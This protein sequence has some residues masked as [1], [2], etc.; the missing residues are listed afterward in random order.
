V[1]VNLDSPGD[2]NAVG[3]T[4]TYDSSLTF[5][6]ATPGSG[7]GGA[8]LTVNTSQTGSGRVGVIL[9][10]PTGNAYGSGDKE[11]VKITLTATTAGVFPL[12][13]TDQQ[14]TRSV[15]DALANELAASYVN[16]TL[17]V[18]ST[19]PPPTLTIA[20]A[21]TNATLSWPVWA[22]DF[23]L[24]MADGTVPWPVVWSNAP[25]TLQTNAGGI[26]TLWP[27]TNRTEYFRLRR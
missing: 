1:F 11:L 19:N 20:I 4:L 24:Q 21:G 26:Y 7:N 17:A 16:G 25:V 22:G 15:S 3:F 14:A 9:G 6:S 10:L 13:L 2:E 27:V 8:N 18:N 5:V 23:V 12:T